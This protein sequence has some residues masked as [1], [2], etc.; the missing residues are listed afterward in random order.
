MVRVMTGLLLAI[1]GQALAAT[2]Y[3]DGGNAGAKDDNDG[4]QG[5]PWRTIQKA[6]GAAKAGDTVIV[7]AGVY[8]AVVT[9]RASGEKD[10]PITF[11]ADPRRAAKVK[12]FVVEAN[13]VRIEGFEV[14]PDQEKANGIFCGE[15]HYET[16]RTGCEIVD[17]YI[18][19]ADG[20]AIVAGVKATVRG[21]LMRNVGR[22]VFVNSGCLVENNE[23]DGLMVKVFKKDGNEKVRSAKYAFFAGDDIVFRGNYWHGT[24]MERMKDLGCCFFGS[25]DAWKFGPSHRVLIENNR[26]FN[27]THASEPVGEDKKQSSHIT[28]RNN[29]FVNTVYVGVLPKEWTHVTIV[30]NTFINCGAY[31]V[32]FQTERQCEGSVVRNNLIAYYKHT[33]AKGALAAESGIANYAHPKAKIDCDYNMFWGCKN[34]GY[35]KNDFTA[36]PQFVDPDN[37]D[38]RL[39]AGSPGID[40]G[41][42]VGIKSDLE[43]TPRPQG[44]A[45]DIGAFEYHAA[46][47]K[48]TPKETE[49]K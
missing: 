46:D 21:N 15:A 6:A 48:A 27:A 16:A 42:D 44:K 17:N 30:H 1:A 19:D 37:G 14:V 40:Q 20:T 29:L 2:Y 43:G 8:D 5:T 32:W 7:G 45:V 25:W 13:H 33:P 24:P 3:V 49:G 23:I 38:F 36:E 12:G 10:R 39:K 22:G 35:G 26:C 4:S 31:P 9:I 34:R 11:Q 28:Y 18:H 47:P 41:T